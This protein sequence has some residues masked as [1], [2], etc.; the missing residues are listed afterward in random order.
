MINQNLHL[1]GVLTLIHQQADGTIQQQHYD[2]LIM[3]AG[4]DFIADSLGNVANRPD[5]MN[6][7]ALGTGIEDTTPEQTTLSAELDRNPA[8]YQH[9]PGQVSFSFS[10]QF[11]AGDATGAIT[12]AGVF[13]ASK[14]GI[15]F[16][17]VTFPV[18]NKGKDDTLTTVFTFT[19][20]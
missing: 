19:M 20:S 9:T 5:V 12:E 17:R 15:M 1:H 13:N 7:I 14:G 11:P 2:N 18:V 16:D 4:Y 8:S 10:A 3:S 6:Y